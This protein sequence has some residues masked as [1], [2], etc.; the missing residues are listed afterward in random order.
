M[1]FYFHFY[2]FYFNINHIPS[3]QF[4]VATVFNLV[5]YDYFSS[6]LSILSLDYNTFYFQ[7]LYFLV[8][9]SSVL[10]SFLEIFFVNLFKT[11]FFF[12]SFSLNIQIIFFLQCPNDFTVVILNSLYY[13][14]VFFFMNQKIIAHL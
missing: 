8:L 10:F 12:L 4:F 13:F 5:S 9:S 1:K 6:S 7:F 3:P 11:Y 2:Q 14:P